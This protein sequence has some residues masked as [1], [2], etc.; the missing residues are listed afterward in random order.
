MSIIFRHP[1]T[2]QIILYCKGADSSILNNLV[3]DDG[4]ICIYDFNITVRRYILY[5]EIFLSQFSD[6]EI[7]LKTKQH[8]SL[9]S[10]TYGLRTL[11]MAYRIIDESEYETWLKGHNLAENSLI[12][13]EK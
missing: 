3:E 2:N 6:I 13:Q 1:T 11:C 8:L 10:A 9:Y 12:N 5:L 4:M 7:L